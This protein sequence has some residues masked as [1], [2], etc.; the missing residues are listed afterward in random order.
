MSA[1]QPTHP[2]FVGCYKVP[3]KKKEMGRQF[4]VMDNRVH[5]QQSKNEPNRYVIGVKSKIKFIVSECFNVR[6]A[7]G[8]V[9]DAR[10]IIQHDPTAHTVCVMIDGPQYDA[11]RCIRDKCGDKKQVSYCARPPSHPHASEEE[12]ER[13]REK[14]KEKNEKEKNEK[15]N[16]KEKEKDVNKEEDKDKEKQMEADEHTAHQPMKLKERRKLVSIRNLPEKLTI[17]NGGVPVIPINEKKCEWIKGAAK[18]VRRYADLRKIQAEIILSKAKNERRLEVIEQINKRKSATNNKREQT[19]MKSRGKKK[20]CFAE[21]TRCINP[22]IIAEDRDK[23]SKCYTSYYCVARHR[24]VAEKAFKCSLTPTLYKE[25]T[26]WNTG[27]YEVIQSHHS[28]RHYLDIEWLTKDESTGPDYLSLMLKMARQ[29]FAGIPGNPCRRIYVTTGSRFINID[30]P[31]MKM[32]KHSYHIIFPDLVFQGL[33]DQKLV[34]RHFRAFLAHK[35]RFENDQDVESLALIATH[36]KRE[37]LAAIGW[38]YDHKVYTSN[39]LMRMENQSKVTSDG[40]RA[41]PMEVVKAHRDLQ[42]HHVFVQDGVMI[43]VRGECKKKKISG[44]TAP[45]GYDGEMMMNNTMMLAGKHVRY[46]E[47]LHS[48][49][50]EMAFQKYL[51]RKRKQCANEKSNNDAE[52]KQLSK[53]RKTMLQSDTWQNEN[54]RQRYQQ[55][56]AWNFSKTTKESKDRIKVMRAINPFFPH[57]YS[58]YKDIDAASLR[59]YDFVQH[60]LNLIQALIAVFGVEEDDIVEWANRSNV[61]AARRDYRWARERVAAERKTSD[62]NVS[63]WYYKI[64]TTYG[65]VRERE[66]KYEHI[67]KQRWQWFIGEESNGWEKDIIMNS[68]QCV[69]NIL[70]LHESAMKRDKHK[71]RKRL[72]G[73]TVLG[74]CETFCFLKGVMGGGKTETILSAL[75]R[76]EVG[77]TVALVVGRIEM[78]NEL[79]ERANDMYKGAVNV[80]HYQDVLTAS[81]KRV[82]GAK[83]AMP[84]LGTL[85]PNLV[86]NDTSEFKT[87][88]ELEHIEQSEIL[89]VDPSSFD[90]FKTEKF[91]LNLLIT[92]VNSLHRFRTH[93]FDMIVVDEFE[94]AIGNLTLNMSDVGYV[95]EAM[96]AAATVVLCDAMFTAPSYKLPRRLMKASN[97]ERKRMLKESQMMDTVVVMDRNVVNQ[98]KWTDVQI[99]TM[100]LEVPLNKRGI[101]TRVTYLKNDTVHMHSSGTSSEAN[102]KAT[103]FIA[104]LIHAVRDLNQ[105]VVITVPTRI[106][107]EKIA[108]IMRVVKNEQTNGNSGIAV[109]V[110]TSKARKPADMSLINYARQFDVFIY[111]SVISAGHS[112]WCDGWFHAT[113]AL[114]MMPNRDGQS[115]VPPVSEQVQ[116]TGRVRDNSSGDLFF[117]IL[118]GLRNRERLEDDNKTC[119]KV[120][121]QSVAQ[122]AKRIH[123]DR[124]EYR[125]WMGSA[126]MP[127]LLYFLFEF[128]K[129]VYP[130]A[131]PVVHKEEDVREQCVG[132]DERYHTKEA[133]NIFFKLKEKNEK[134]MFQMQMYYNVYTELLG[135]CCEADKLFTR[136]DGNY[137]PIPI[138]ENDELVRS[139]REDGKRVGKQNILIHF[140]KHDALPGKVI[141]A[142]CET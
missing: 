17:A 130:Q 3:S 58:S 84:W 138:S 37:T 103:G 54:I 115:F 24:D 43:N 100:R 127:H 2:L 123:D 78:V 112:L 133:E 30:D 46:W 51:S 86:L 101:F 113:Y 66:Q 22:L 56:Q 142:G 48:A 139:I 73:G 7:V 67:G 72:P 12:K 102:M 63:G 47:Q 61:A 4:T 95:F 15:E 76:V 5:T 57:V 38:V 97:K 39:R 92:C 65:L 137:V 132:F 49:K 129:Q 21:R 141:F 85:P 18:P 79:V 70:Q 20:T 122:I 13:A 71:D 125:R 41:K 120:A 89:T 109:G 88:E 128:F 110:V 91:R 14:E 126:E 11:E 64:L 107:A 77:E 26:V 104:R 106:W 116:M 55:K 136:R 32:Y 9:N 8:L 35:A 96:K 121:C 16:Q 25:L 33:A 124:M 118:A 90:V 105:R 10:L 83:N 50:E 6:N 68:K 1:T 59:M 75:R 87:P 140:Q 40:Q 135:N 80:L 28:R 60:Y 27:K 19:S 131:G 52:H 74:G 29:F 42:E 111:T 93:R 44:Y 117:T 98:D 69:D 108:G 36:H 62:K 23:G 53:K 114:L 34:D 94:T 45:N 82:E 134:I 81:E 119:E 99:T 31:K